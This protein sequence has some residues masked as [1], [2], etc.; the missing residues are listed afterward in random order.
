MPADLYLVARSK[1]SSDDYPS[2]ADALQW[3]KRDENEKAEALQWIKRD[4]N[5]KAEALQWI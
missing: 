5:E 1:Q 3:I 4:E 2:A